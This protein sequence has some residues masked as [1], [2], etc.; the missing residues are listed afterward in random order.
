[1]VLLE[2]PKRH[3]NHNGATLLFGPDHDLYVSLGD[4][5]GAGDPE[6][7][8]QNLGD[9]HGKILRLDVD[10]ESG[11]LQ[12]P[13]PEDNPFAGKPGD[14][15]EVWAYGLRNVWRMSFDRAT[16]DLWA[17]DVGQDAWEEVDLIVK[18]GNYGWNLREGKHPYG[19]E[20]GGA[21]S[22]QSAL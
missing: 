20:S 17:G 21:A 4:G 12:Y 14:R 18:G 8:A 1:V 11:G 2:L 6:G 22:G 9:L 16:G 10:H 3:G 19:R 13:I 5:G 7:N 15:G